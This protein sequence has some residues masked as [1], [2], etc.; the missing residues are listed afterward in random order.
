MFLDSDPV[1]MTNDEYSQQAIPACL[2]TRGFY[3][4]LPSPEEE[5]SSST[6]P[7][8]VMLKS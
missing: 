3:S 6:T 8:D 4:N 1:D 2:N 7:E 5:P